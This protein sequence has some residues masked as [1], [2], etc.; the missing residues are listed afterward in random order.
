MLVY[1]QSLNLTS[2]EITRWTRN[3]FLTFIEF[4]TGDCF[5]FKK[6]LIYHKP[7]A[8]KNENIRKIFKKNRSKNCTSI[9]LFAQS[10]VQLN[11]TSLLDSKFLEA[12]AECFKRRLVLLKVAG[13]IINQELS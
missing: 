8:N 3:F 11:N 1:H 4:F 6:C 13:L 7:R 10:S 9:K 2:N 12:F 5:D